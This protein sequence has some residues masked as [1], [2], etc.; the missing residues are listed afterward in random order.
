VREINRTT[1]DKDTKVK[2]RIKEW[3]FAMSNHIAQNDVIGPFAEPT[4]AD[5][6]RPAGGNE[7]NANPT[8]RKTASLLRRTKACLVSLWRAI[9]GG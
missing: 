9:R 8:S 5:P 6:Y 1:Y 3:A 4:D 7:A 2:R